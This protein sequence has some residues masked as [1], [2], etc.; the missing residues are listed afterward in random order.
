MSVNNTRSLQHICA[1]Y[2]ARQRNRL[3]IKLLFASLFFALLTIQTP[4]SGVTVMHQ[5]TGEV[6][7]VRENE[8]LEDEHIITHDMTITGEGEK[9][10]TLTLVGSLTVANGARLTLRNITL[11]QVTQNTLVVIGTESTVIL[12]NSTLAFADDYLLR[13]GHFEFIKIASLS[14]NKT[15]TLATPE[16]ST[17]AR[18]SILFID[19]LKVVAA[20]SP[21]VITLADYSSSLL[22]RNGVLITTKTP[23][24]FTHGVLC[25]DGLCKTIAGS[26][27][28][29]T[30]FIFGDDMI[31]V[32]NTKI[33]FANKKSTLRVEAPPVII[34]NVSE[35]LPD[36]VE[37]FGPEVLIILYV[38]SCF[39]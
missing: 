20:N 25:I 14:G 26:R 34:D 30:A 8:V 27:S 28:E 3:I 19:H 13:E 32:N 35:G 5:E 7:S 31:A 9:E 36:L 33:W 23:W 1:D 16:P 11:S 18:A 12:D 4:L 10:I 29:E 38:S 37:L 15:L 24:I 17:I 6:I 22:M 21:Y 39:C 2:E